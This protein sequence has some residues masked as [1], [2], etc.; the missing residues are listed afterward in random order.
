MK[1][2]ESKALIY[3][4][5]TSGKTRSRILPKKEIIVPEH[6][7]TYYAP[8]SYAIDMFFAVKGKP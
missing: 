2:P 5:N 8:L 7:S 4:A 1:V 6:S 3:S